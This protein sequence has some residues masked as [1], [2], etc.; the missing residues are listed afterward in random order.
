M[1]SVAGKVPGSGPVVLTFGSAE[2]H[3]DEELCAGV[4]HDVPGPG[5]RH[6]DNHAPAAGERQAGV[7]GREHEWRW[8]GSGWLKNGIEVA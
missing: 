6:E 2:E 5:G 1:V 7:G 8:A 4:V 3:D